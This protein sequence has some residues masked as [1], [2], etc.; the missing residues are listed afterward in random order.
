MKE[1]TLKLVFFCGLLVSSVALSA[2]V[3]KPAVLKPSDEAKWILNVNN[4][5]TADGSSVRDVLAYAERVR[6]R[7]FKVA[8]IDVGY[9]GATGKPD[10]VFI[11]YWIG[12]NRKEGDQFIDLGYPMTKNGAIAT[13]DLKDRPTL[14]ALEKGRESFLHEIDSIYSENCVQPGTTERLC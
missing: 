5:Q 6:P 9:N 13:I 4:H 3:W 11:G 8:K 2:G 12:R 10:S 14:T 7:Q 1:S